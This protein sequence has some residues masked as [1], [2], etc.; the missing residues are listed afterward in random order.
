MPMAC[1]E[2]HISEIKTLREWT[3]NCDLNMPQLQIDLTLQLMM[4][5]ETSSL[6]LELVYLTQSTCLLEAPSVRSLPSL[7]KGSSF[8][9]LKCM[10]INWSTCQMHDSYVKICWDPGEGRLSRLYLMK[11]FSV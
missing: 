3:Y 2:S 6:T 7:L 10:Y 1:W 5:E 8:S 9:I 4:C 11:E